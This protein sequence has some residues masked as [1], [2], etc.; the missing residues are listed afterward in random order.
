MIST[1]A[2][3]SAVAN[4]PTPIRRRNLCLPCKKP[5]ECDESDVD[6]DLTES[7]HIR[8]LQKKR[9]AAMAELD[10]DEA[11]DDDDEEEEEAAKKPK[12][13]QEQ[14][15]EIS[16]YSSAASTPPPPPPAE[17]EEEEAEAAVVD[18]TGDS[19]EDVQRRLLVEVI[20]MVRESDLFSLRERFFATAEDADAANMAEDPPTVATFPDTTLVFHVAAEAGNPA[21]LRWLHRHVRTSWDRHVACAAA[22]AGHSICLEYL[23][24]HGC[25]GDPQELCASAA[26]GGHTTVLHMLFADYDARCDHR[27][28]EAALLGGGTSAVLRWLMR[29][30]V[31]VSDAAWAAA[32]LHPSDALTMCATLLDQQVYRPPAAWAAWAAT[33]PDDRVMSL[34][35]ARHAPCRFADA[36]VCAGAAAR[37]TPVLLEMAHRVWG[38]R[39]DESAALAA[40]S[41]SRPASLEYCLRVLPAQTAQSRA[42]L[43]RALARTQEHDA[44]RVRA[45]RALLMGGRAATSMIEW[46][47]RARA[48]EE[49]P[50]DGEQEEKDEQQK[51][52]EQKEEEESVVVVV[53]V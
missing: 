50:L 16:D 9:S 48:R 12:T 53:V 6:D 44:G 35:I 52:D 26:R 46:L 41:A 39:L 24:D 42:T 17:E 22:F 8:R 4:A 21:V 1:P 25:P 14:E 19:A 20:E 33:A 28:V 27:A 31:P 18:L 23:L 13:E 47:M 45:C 2:A 32:I 11:D 10:M 30:A 36:A 51:D 5:S 7:E 29:Q 3:S 49:P 15:E 40:V 43:L 38:W 34:F 37:E